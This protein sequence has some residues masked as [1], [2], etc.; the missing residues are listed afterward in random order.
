[1]ASKWHGGCFSQYDIRELEPMCVCVESEFGYIRINQKPLLNDGVNGF[2]CRN[3]M[4]NKARGKYQSVK[5]YPYIYKKILCQLL[6]FAMYNYFI[7]AYHGIWPK[8]TKDWNLI[9]DEY[10]A[11]R[12]TLEP[13]RER[14]RERNSSYFFL[15]SSSRIQIRCKWEN[16]DSIYGSSWARFWIH[17]HS[18]N[19]S[20]NLCAACDHVDIILWNWIKP[21]HVRLFK[22]VVFIHILNT[23]STYC[24]PEYTH[25]L[26]HTQHCKSNE[27][28][29]ADNNYL[30][31]PLTPG[32]CMVKTWKQQQHTHTHTLGVLHFS[33]NVLFQQFFFFF[34][35]SLRFRSNW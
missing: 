10:Y 15:F 34:W 7:R 31:T 16:E 2:G 6:T 9:S 30:I 20:W 35:S 17:F 27:I 23:S 33:K 26:T 28:R 18:E 22:L 12:K 4:W 25:I 5:A 14:D 1:M 29:Y 11:M 32:T 21:Y 8:R 24:S 19:Y 13:G 3:Q